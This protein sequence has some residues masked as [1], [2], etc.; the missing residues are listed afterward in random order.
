MVVGI[1]KSLRACSKRS[2]S[3]ARSY[4][5]NR[6]KDGHTCFCQGL[7][8]LFDH[9]IRMMTSL[10]SLNCLY[11]LHFLMSMVQSRQKF[12]EIVPGFEPMIQ[13]V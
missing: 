13:L 1:S 11:S 9:Q 6:A 2:R 4:F 12:V 8:R 5:S 7:L 3:S 10:V